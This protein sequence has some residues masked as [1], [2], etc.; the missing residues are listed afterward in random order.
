MPNTWLTIDQVA[1][2]SGWSK[3][4]IRR[5][6]STSRIQTRDKRALCIPGKPAREYAL[7]SLPVEA[8]LKFSQAAAAV[9]TSLYGSGA[10]LGSE[11]IQPVCFSA[12]DCRARAPQLFRKAERTGLEAPGGDCAARGIQQPQPAIPS[13]VPYHRR[14]CRAKHE[15]AG[16]LPRRSAPCQRS[17]SLELVCTV[18]QARLCRSGRPC[19]VG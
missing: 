1:L 13:N 11:P 7:S 18:P 4:H 17:N 8:Q 3:R 5:L 16:R 19:S 2:L 10:S 15:L 9:W 6:A 14:S 12:G